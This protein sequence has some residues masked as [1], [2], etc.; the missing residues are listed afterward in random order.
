M[1][2][3]VCIY[4]YVCCRVLQRVAACYT[5]VCDRPEQGQR[6][7]AFEEGVCRCV[8]QCVAVCS[9]AISVLQCVAVCHSVVHCCT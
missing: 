2:V 9:S 4:V 8:L 5:A 3:Y 7:I 6:V 1:C